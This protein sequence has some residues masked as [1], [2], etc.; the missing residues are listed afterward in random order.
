MFYWALSLVTSLE[1]RQTKIDA[2]RQSFLL[3]WSLAFSSNLMPSRK[4]GDM[5][6]VHKLSLWSDKEL[7]MN[8]GFVI[9]KLRDLEEVT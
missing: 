6:S 9:P 3:G 4:K 1:R 5:Q 2:R 8:H 7:G